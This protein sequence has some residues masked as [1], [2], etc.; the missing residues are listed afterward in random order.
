MKSFRLIALQK[1]ISHTSKRKQQQMHT[2]SA[3]YDTV[4]FDT[5]KKKKTRST[6]DLHTP[7]F[8]MGKQYPLSQSQRSLLHEEGKLNPASTDAKHPW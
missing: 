5:C 2:K 6:R 8:D 1:Q 3:L 4:P 7:M